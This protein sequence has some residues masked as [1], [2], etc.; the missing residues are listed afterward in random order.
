MTNEKLTELASELENCGKALLRIASAMQAPQDEQ[1][2]ES[3]KKE[4][5]KQPLALEDV[6][7]VAADK[8]RQGFT[9]EVRSLIQKHGANN[10]SSVDAAQYSTL[11]KEL[12]AIGHAG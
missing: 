11:L 10:L 9:D 8:A 3:E 2:A 5:A 7:K 1:P 12:E 4:Y 6:R